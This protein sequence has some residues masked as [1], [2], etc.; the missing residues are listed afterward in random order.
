[1]C[2]CACGGRGNASGRKPRV[3]RHPS[4][5]RSAARNISDTVRTTAPSIQYLEAAYCTSQDKGIHAACRIVAPFSRNDAVR[6]RGE[7]REQARP[8]TMATDAS[9]PSDRARAQGHRARPTDKARR[10]P[11]TRPPTKTTSVNE[12]QLLP[13]PALPPRLALR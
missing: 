5:H 10:R 9:T 3:D 1:M 7:D 2:V 12:H 6:D 11:R 13:P 8:E 4:F